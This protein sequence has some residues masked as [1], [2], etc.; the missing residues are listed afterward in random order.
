MGKGRNGRFIG[1]RMTAAHSGIMNL[2]IEWKKPVP[3]RKAPRRARKG[4][5]YI[6]KVDLEVLPAVPG[7]Y[8]FARRWSKSY[9]AL[10]VGQSTN[11]RKRVRNHLKNLPLMKYLENAKTG[12]R[13]VI[14]GRAVPRPG[15]KVEKVLATL[16]RAFIRHFLSEGHALVNKQ[17]TRIRR[18]EI[19][20]EGKVPKSFIPTWMYLERAK[21]Q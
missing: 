7:I 4:S 3:L 5:L 1:D 16:E 9:E 18:H 13:F 17:G 6:Y 12:G 2:E 8:V 20:S 11:I 15:H 19:F 10:Y 14:V 21:G